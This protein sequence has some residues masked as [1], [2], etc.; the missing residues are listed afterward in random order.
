MITAF[1]VG[2]L[3]VLIGIGLLLGHGMAKE[4][5]RKEVAAL[6]AAPEPAPPPK[7]EP[8]TFEERLAAAGILAMD[9]FSP[10]QPTPEALGRLY[11]RANRYPKYETATCR[12]CNEK[13]SEREYDLYEVVKKKVAA[14]ARDLGITEWRKLG[15][16]CSNCG[17]TEKRENE[18]FALGERYASFDSFL[19]LV[20]TIEQ[21]RGGLSR[22]KR[23][24][25]L[26]ER[27]AALDDQRSAVAKA[28]EALEPVDDPTTHPYRRSG[29]AMP[30]E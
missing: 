1:F 26:A 19:N 21:E 3:V 2:I 13:I 14:G 8:P 12:Y 6:T 29:G 25:L 22:E 10:G 7:P 28:L 16:F 23:K 5:S 24:A 30:A 17:T 4:L 18:S 20:E 27:I 11:A 15:S 9:L